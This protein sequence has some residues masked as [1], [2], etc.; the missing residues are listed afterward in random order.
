LS[1]TT[2]PFLIADHPT[3][4][5]HHFIPLKNTFPPKTSRSATSLKITNENP[6][7]GGQTKETLDLPV[8][9]FGTRP[10]SQL[11]YEFHAGL[12]SYFMGV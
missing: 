2:L 1:G 7:L 9:K 5:L 6:T 8:S 10:T 12:I 4:V 11:Y 3:F